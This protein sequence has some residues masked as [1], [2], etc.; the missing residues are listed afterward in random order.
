MLCTAFGHLQCVVLI[1]HAHKFYVIDDSLMQKAS[2]KKKTT[3]VVSVRIFSE[4]NHS[5]VFKEPVG[6]TEHF[7]HE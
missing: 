1:S 3:D 2:L 7:E 5:S 6:K 4:G